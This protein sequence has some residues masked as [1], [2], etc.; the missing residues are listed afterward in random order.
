[1]KWWICVLGIGLLLSGCGAE[2]TFETVGDEFAAQ[3]MVSAGKMEVALPPEAMVLAMNEDLQGS[4]YLCPRYTVTMQTFASGDMKST[5]QAVSG[6]KN[7]E[8]FHTKAGKVERYDW[9]WS[10]VE[11]AG[12]MISRA[13]VLDDGVYHYALCVTAPAGEA[14][15]LEQEWERLFA[16][17]KI[18]Q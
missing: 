17:L 2:E 18:N 9:V 8:L 4:V 1:M 11:E 10:T 3:V 6:L 5:V 7:A 14:G 15:A 12:D 16:S 13:A